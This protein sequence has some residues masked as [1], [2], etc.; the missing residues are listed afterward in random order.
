MY[1]LCL[2]YQAY[3]EIISKN[4]DEQN[5][6]I[7]TMDKL[8]EGLWKGGTRVKK[9]HSLN[10]K[11]CIYEARND[12]AR[13][14]LFSVH[15]KKQRDNKDKAIIYVHCISLAHDDVIRT[16]KNILNED[17]DDER[18]Y[19]EKECRES[20]NDI[21]D[22][23]K[24]YPE[25]Y[26]VYLY[27][28]KAKFNIL[29]EEDLIRFFNKNHHSKDEILEFE[30]KLK[31][32]Q[33]EILEK[34][35][36]LLISGTAG[37]GKTTLLLHKLLTNSFEH[38][39]YITS[40]DQLCKEAKLQFEKLVRGRDE[41]KE[42]L[43]NTDFLTFKEF[44]ENYKTDKLQTIISKEG[45]IAKYKK[46]ART[47][48]MIEKFPPLMIWEEI[49]GVWKGYRGQS[50]NKMTFNEYSSISEK[51][52]PNF[53][54]CRKEAYK[55]Y[56][57]Y[58]SLLKEEYLVDELDLI[59]V[60]INSNK[61]INKK[62]FITA[63]DEVQDITTVHL[64]LLFSLSGYNSGKL[65]LAGD[66]N[67]I[68]NHSGFRWENIKDTFYK[69]LN[70]PKPQLYELNVNY[71]SD[72]FI[73]N[74][75][76]SI[77]EFQDGFLEKRYVSK[78]ENSLF[79]GDMP[80]LIINLSEE[81]MLDNIC[82]LNSGQA[83]L[84]KNSNEEEKLRGY[85]KNKFG[86]VPLIFT[87]EESKGLEFSSVILWKLTFD[88]NKEWE[89][90][91]RKKEYGREMNNREK[92]FI[93]YE[94]SM[95]YVAVT[96]AMKNCIIYDSGEILE[97]W[98]TNG[99]KNKIEV[100]NKIDSIYY[101]LN[102]PQNDF[103]WFEQGKVLLSKKKYI[104]AIEC[105]ERI[106]DKNILEEASK[107]KKECIALS[108]IENGDLEAAARLYIQLNKIEEAAKCYDD[109]AM[110]MEA[111]NLY[112]SQLYG[113][114]DMKKKYFYEAKYYDSIKDWHKSACI[115]SADEKH[116]EAAIRFEKSQE[117]NDLKRAAHIYETIL[118]NY[119]KA[120]QCY[121]LAGELKKAER[122]KNKKCSE[123]RVTFT[124]PTLENDVR[125]ALNKIDNLKYSNSNDNIYT[126]DV[127]LIR[128]LPLYSNNIKS[129]KGVEKLKN[130]E[131]FAV[132]CNTIKDFGPLASLINLTN[133][134]I[135]GNVIEDMSVIYKLKNLKELLIQ[136]SKVKEINGIEKLQNL[137]TLCLASNE[138]EDISPITKLTK[139]KCLL[140]DGNRIKD[141]N[142]L[143]KLQN[144]ETLSIGSNEI[145][146]ISPIGK[147]TKLKSL[148]INNNK[149][150]DIS[151]LKNL[152]SLGTLSLNNN[153]IFNVRPLVNLN[154]L[155][156]LYLD[157][158]RIEDY[159]S[160]KNLKLTRTD[161]NLGSK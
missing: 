87:I 15:P 158:N 21:I 60:Y 100:M 79:C 57:W 70:C 54:G 131:D 103:Q 42:Y 19:I 136:Q 109:A 146:D 133:V 125:G 3:N 111:A 8:R 90:L 39:L 96:R 145:R 116:Y 68:V 62:Y 104:Q 40:S 23:E 139:L 97:F 148:S 77:N 112:G 10:R 30:I 49:R 74:L 140:I 45:F 102:E 84:V 4:K 137:E 1:E 20:L 11:K 122:C 141:L 85:F 5:N 107:L 14:M 71:R 88:E 93:R 115:C 156:V 91:L 37:S 92:K 47:N 110:Y 98:N 132:V 161:V 143:D 46:Y 58:E 105:F 117:T 48:G 12:G 53:K 81:A 106:V 33:K 7:D 95:I 73:V 72:G 80:K 89:K 155:R 153:M 26:Q 18:Y 135:D 66:D 130:L 118:E 59:K 149:I 94:A 25:Q 43:E 152:T 142:G 157:G 34:P 75:A 119:D 32:E 61:S 22:K 31:E 114:K 150:K 9:L 129:L 27:L 28:E 64:L 16:A 63:C 65:I 128:S 56:E 147:L 86:K 138:I 83:V 151:V 44:L 36:P 41:E 123:N 2:S 159:T 121:E 101:I 51:A 113:R 160:L 17:Y 6:I 69:Y 13:R 52:A 144:L 126:W 67:Q 78:P 29:K 50:G 38:K 127:E 99:I 24:F 55:I 134:F 154:N 76:N 120:I 82:N 108:E 124:D 35:L